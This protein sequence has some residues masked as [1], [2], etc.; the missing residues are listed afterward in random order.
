M[1]RIHDALRKVEQHEATSSPEVWTNT[2]TVGEHP[3]ASRTHHITT[4]EAVH[5]STSPDTDTL[6]N[7]RS[8]SWTFNKASMLDFD[9]GHSTRASEEFRMLRSRLYQ[10]RSAQP[11]KSVVI[12]SALSGE[13][14]SFVA[15]NLWQALSL[16]PDRRVLLI[17]GDLRT[18]RL[19]TFLGTA[20]EPGLS[21]CLETKV[22][23]RDAL[24]RG[25]G[26]NAFF[27]PA[28][29]PWPR[30]SDLISDARVAAF[31]KRLV[32]CFDWVII[33]A[34]STI[35]TSD[36]SSLAEIADGVLLVVRANATPS[37][38]VQSALDRFNEDRL[39]GVVLN[40]IVEAPTEEPA[41]PAGGQYGK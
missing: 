32:N 38:I 30:P 8:V 34:P 25:N 26:N 6:L 12:T 29:N 17:D 36:S 19:H 14:K 22:D 27:I 31:V 41:T 16:H 39:L 11:L 3:T 10:A 4:K 5:A 24:Q 2:I 33:D 40:E 23:L 21:E 37:D 1:S 20:K 7:C 13:G 15:A 28:G 9:K 35:E 18:P